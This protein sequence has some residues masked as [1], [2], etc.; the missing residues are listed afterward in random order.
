[1]FHFLLL[2]CPRFVYSVLVSADSLLV[3]SN[4]LDSL[5]SLNYTMLPRFGLLVVGLF[6]VSWFLLMVCSPWLSLFL[7][8][9]SLLLFSTNEGGLDLLSRQLRRELVS[10][11]QPSKAAFF[12]DDF[13]IL[14]FGLGIPLWVQFFEYLQFLQSVYVR[15]F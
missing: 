3:C 4:L 2:R 13:R 5:P 10:F 12:Y 6:L 7:V 11:Q 1:M 9:G 15:E 14:G 8:A